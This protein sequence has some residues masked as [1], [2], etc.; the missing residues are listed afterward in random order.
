VVWLWIALGA[1]V[2]GAAA[3]LIAG[4]RL[5]RTHTASVTAVYTAPPAAVWQAI[6]D[7]RALPTWRRDV[8]RVEELRSADGAEGWV[9]HTRSGRLPFAIER[10]EPERLLVGRVADPDLPFGGTWTYRLE[11]EGAERTRVTITE[12]GHIGPPLFRFLARY[13]FGYHGTMK[14]Y[15]RALGGKLGSAVEP[16]RVESR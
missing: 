2:L 5:P 3:G 1:V 11:P 10:E 6:R 9:E 7:W 12:D 8:R 13:V 16:Q 15:L 14:A 4:A